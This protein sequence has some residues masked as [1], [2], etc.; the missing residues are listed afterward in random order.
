M[1]RCQRM[2]W[3]QLTGAQALYVEIAGADGMSFCAEASFAAQQRPMAIFLDEGQPAFFGLDP[4]FAHH[5]AESRA[6]REMLPGAEGSLASRSADYPGL[7]GW[8]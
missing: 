8:G 7:E 4:G 5:C 2:K 3:T 6:W 1:Y